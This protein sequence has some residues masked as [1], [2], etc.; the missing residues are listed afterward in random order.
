MTTLRLRI[1]L[2]KEE[3]GR[4]LAAVTSRGFDGIMAYGPTVGEA[5]ENL[6]K[7]VRR[8]VVDRVR[9]KEPVPGLVLDGRKRLTV[10]F[11]S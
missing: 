5:R 11:F 6:R 8:V 4:L 7:L 10:V 9:H 2:E 3:D 1:R